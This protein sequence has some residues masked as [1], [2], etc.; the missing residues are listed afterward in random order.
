MKKLFGEVQMALGNV[1][2]DVMGGGTRSRSRQFLGER[3]MAPER[4]TFSIAGL[5][6]RQL[7]PGQLLSRAMAKLA[8]SSSED[9]EDAL[10]AWFPHGDGEPVRFDT[11]DAPEHPAAATGAIQSP[12]WKSM[13]G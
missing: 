9:R 10:K 13:F 7:L 1:P 4:D 6:H 12:S 2:E 8:T 5:Q 11:E 3:L